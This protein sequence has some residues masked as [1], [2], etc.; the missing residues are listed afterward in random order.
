MTE[1]QNPRRIDVHHHIIPDCYRNALLEMGIGR[2]GG[3]SIG[4]WCPEDSLE[5]MEKGGIETG[6]C[7]VSEPALYPF[8]YLDKN[9]ARALARKVNEEIADLCLTY[10]GRFGGFA[11]LPMP[12]IEGSLEEL[13]YALDVLHLDGVGL[14]SN[15][16]DR[17]LG[18]SCFHE[19]FEELQK[20]KAVIYVHPSVP[21]KEMKK[22]EFVPVDFLEEF[23]FNTTRAAANL[24]Y[25]GTMER[26][27][28]LKFIFSH[29]G[30]TLPYLRWRLE[31]S[32]EASRRAKK[33]E[34]ENQVWRAWDSLEKSIPE[35]MSMFYFDTAL[36]TH[37]IALEA[38]EITAPGHTLFGSDSFYASEELL[39]VMCRHLDDYLKEQPER[40]VA[41]NRGNAEKLFPRF[42]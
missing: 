13:A 34:L 15:Y 31:Y 7:S 23:C 27:P 6:I 11:L 14:L 36:S 8:V 17:F 40:W 22:P 1:N 25:S 21:Q 33:L 9:K 4:K 37:A 12:D 29:M 10:S 20:R 32:F 16:Q 3:K 2:S 5:F 41:V 18:D 39:H 35:Y 26:C 38:V 30:G 28:D 42:Q 19:L 24:I